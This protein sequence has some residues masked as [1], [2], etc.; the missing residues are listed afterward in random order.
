MIYNITSIYNQYIKMSTTTNNM[1]INK[2]KIQEYNEYMK[3]VYD[4]LKFDELVYVA[5]N[6]LNE[7]NKMNNKNNDEPPA[8]RTK[9]N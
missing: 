9:M 5:I 2:V 4:V 8:K 3:C 7:L 6:E 1:N